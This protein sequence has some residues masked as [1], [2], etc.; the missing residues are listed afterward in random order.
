MFTLRVPASSANLGPGFDAL[1]VAVKMHLEIEIEPR[2]DLIAK[3]VIRIG[4]HKFLFMPLCDEGF[5]WDD[6]GALR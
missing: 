5:F 3:D 4:S 2:R 6:E 1:G